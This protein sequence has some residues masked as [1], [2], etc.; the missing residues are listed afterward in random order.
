[1]GAQDPNTK[2]SNGWLLAYLWQEKQRTYRLKH[3]NTQLKHVYNDRGARKVLVKQELCPQHCRRPRTSAYVSIT[4]VSSSVIMHYRIQRMHPSGMP[5]WRLGIFHPLGYR[6]SLLD[7]EHAQG[8]N[9]I[10]IQ[11][12]K[13]PSTVYFGH[14]ILAGGC[15]SHICALRILV[16]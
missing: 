9:A 11:L 2:V 14:A 6:I 7:E 13:F 15:S 4:P 12:L 16:I 8:S 5:L 3:T 1:M 10:Q